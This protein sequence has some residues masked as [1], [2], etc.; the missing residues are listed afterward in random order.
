M[1]G[2]AVRALDAPVVTAL[3]APSPTIL[4]ASRATH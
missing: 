4:L 2:K 3:Y 1:V